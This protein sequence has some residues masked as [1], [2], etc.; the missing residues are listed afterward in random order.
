MKT[1]NVKTN[2]V[3]SVLQATF[4]SAS[5]VAGTFAALFLQSLGYT[6][7]E[8]GT[9]VAGACILGFIL[10]MLISPVI[11]R[12]SK[13]NASIAVLCLQTIGIVVGASIFLI[14]RKGIALSLL[15]VLWYGMMVTTSAM[16]AQVSQDYIH[17][18]HR[19]NF[20]VARA[21]GSLGFVT[22]VSVL[23]NLLEVVSARFLPLFGIAMEILLVL[24]VFL[25]AKAAGKDKLTK[26][27]KTESVQE[28]GSSL[29]TFVKENPNFVMLL[30]GI[31]LIFSASEFFGVYMINVVENLGGT[32]ADMGTIH[33]LSALMEIPSMVLW[34]RISFGKWAKRL[35]VISLFFFAVKNLY[36]AL[37]TSVEMLY[38]GS[39]F[40]MIGYGLYTPAIVDYISK[41]IPYKDSTKA[42]SMAVAMCTLGCV[43]ASLV[44]GILNDRIDIETT[45][46]LDAG[47]TFI[48]AIIAA[49][50]VLRRGR[51]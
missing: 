33:A 16:V 18:G 35:L 9:I 15:Y 31:A 24:S 27:V 8:L 45:L 39:V 22:L 51:C 36:F 46:L 13:L 10:P 30:G 3:Y 2:I 5:G 23:G 47:L 32:A 37:A 44:G 26:T 11:D 4:W 43:V 6:N 40:Q 38:F 21:C 34:T 42:Q 41:N 28:K 17:E 49:T 50:A 48:G 7:T 19:I 14:G 12:S 29:G 20:G 25:L 1:S